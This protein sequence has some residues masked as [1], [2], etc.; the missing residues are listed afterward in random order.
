[1]PNSPK[2]ARPDRSLRATSTDQI[3]VAAGDLNKQRKPFHAPTKARRL[4]K[5][6]PK[7]QYPPA[8][9]TLLASTPHLMSVKPPVII[10]EGS[11]PPVVV[12][13]EDFAEILFTGSTS[14]NFAAKIK[15]G[16]TGII[17]AK[18]LVKADIQVATKK[19]ETLT[20]GVEATKVEKSSFDATGK[21]KLN[22][23]ART[24]TFIK[25]DIS[26][27]DKSDSIK[28]GSKT[29]LKGS[30]N[31]DTNKGSDTVTFAGNTKNKFKGA[32]VVVELGK[33][34]KDVVEFK[35]FKNK[36]KNGSIVIEDFDKKD[37]LKVKGKS[38]N[39]DQLQDKSFKGIEIDFAD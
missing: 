19:G 34:G 38:Y 8:S 35:S 27:T 3:A 33:G 5:R 32:E 37:T 30:M 31:I 26:G 28:F 9:V 6:P 13:T 10:E 29:K 18:P 12:T 4:P 2:S 16:P 11:N 22:F 39:Y 36:I 25:T 20:L 7:H 24:G 14:K 21:G 15:D 17:A 23:Q 1:M